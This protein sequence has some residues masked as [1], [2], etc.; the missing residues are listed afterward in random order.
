MESIIVSTDFSKE[1]E[2]A[3]EY[4]GALA[5]K[6]GMKLVLFNSFRLPLHTANSLLPATGILKLEEG[7]R[8]LLKQKAEI[9]NDRYGV[10]VAIETDFLS[11]VEDKLENLFVKNKAA[12]VVMGMAPKSV[13]QDIFGNTTTSAIFKL[14]YPVLAVPASASF[15]KMD[16]ILFACDDIQKVEKGIIEKIKYLNRLM[17]ARLEVFHVEDNPGEEGGKAVLEEIPE[18]EDVN[19]SVKNLNSENVI[20]AIKKE[21]EH[22]DAKLLIMV[23]R[24]YGFWES[25]IHRSK[26]R[27]MASGLSIPLLT[28][29]Q[30]KENV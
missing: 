1:A 21:I 27:V 9:L 22:L 2:N 14:K 11:E 16:N 19:Y 26:T 20:R 17:E 12:L 25:V 18:L 4:A 15:G 23:P 8:R 3:M 28:I 7:N 29:P 6:T 13:E 24:R 5:Q 30:L 10:E